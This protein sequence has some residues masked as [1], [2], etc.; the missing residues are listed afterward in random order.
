MQTGV[1]FG[2]QG[3]QNINMMQNLYDDVQEYRQVIDEASDIL[4][5][6]VQLKMTDEQALKTTK[7]TQPL[8]VAHSYGLYRAAQKYL[9]TPQMGL[10]LSLGEY[11]ALIAAES[12][13]LA[14][15]LKLVAK[16]GAL[17]QTAVEEFDG[18]MAA[19][20]SDD[21]ATI[22]D[23]LKQFAA[24]GLKV[25]P[26]NYNSPQQ[27]VIGGTPTDLDKVIAIME[28]EKLGR[29]IKLNVAGAF[30]TPLLASAQNEF[31][32]YI[33]EIVFKEPKFLIYSNTT[34]KPF[35]SNEIANTLVKQLVSPTYFAQAL[36]TGSEAHQINQLIEF[37]PDNTLSKFAKKTL[38]NDISRHSIFNQASFEKVQGEFTNGN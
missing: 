11:T 31:S 4:G 14:T 30:H 29:I 24:Q 5:Y 27:L 32:N 6:D 25:Y 37:G 15:G 7:Y 23:N 1:L 3:G 13:D 34:Q 18:T 16:R 38:G 19:I 17:M 21:L 26:A 22:E 33:E 20:I 10:G 35:I 2:G 9:P 28:S 36:V 8:V 12:L